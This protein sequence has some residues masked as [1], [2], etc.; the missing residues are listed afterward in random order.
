MLAILFAR[1][2]FVES[3]VLGD[4]VHQNLHQ[5]DTLLWASRDNKH[6]YEP[7]LEQRFSSYVAEMGRS[8][9]WG[10]ELTLVSKLAMT[11]SH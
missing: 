10:D 1:T 9:T 8:G 3:G 4:S 11:V 7:F 2:L 6:D 5:N